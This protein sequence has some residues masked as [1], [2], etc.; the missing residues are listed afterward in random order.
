MIHRTASLRACAA[1]LGVGLCLALA[2]CAPVPE[3]PT[4]FA[5]TALEQARVPAPAGARPG[6]CWARDVT[7][8]VIETRTA[9]VL[10]QPAILNT[11]GSLLAPA[12][13]ATEIR[14]EIVTPRKEY[15]FET[16][17]AEEI[18]PE[19]I[20]SLQRA[21]QARGRYDGPISGTINPE[22]EAALRL[23]QRA[24]GVETALLTIATARDLGLAAV[25]RS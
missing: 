13:Y 11:D 3:T 22:T 23:Y 9:Q 8:A 4:R 15:V 2:A 25:E 6:S 18:T 19:F 17:C 16:L 20:A 21:L 10:E 12:I 7:P 14:Q 5:F 1:P 24:Q